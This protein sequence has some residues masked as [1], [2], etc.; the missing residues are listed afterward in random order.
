MNWVFFVLV[1]V[2]ISTCIHDQIQNKTLLIESNLDESF[3]LKMKSDLSI[4]SPLKRESIEK[5][6]YAPI[7]IHFETASIL[8]DEKNFQCLNVGD[9]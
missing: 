4:M 2:V 6:L 9:V 7:R 3:I 1:G 8:E 5:D